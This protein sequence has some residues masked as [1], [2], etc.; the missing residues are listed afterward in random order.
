MVLLIIIPFLN[1]YFFGKI[2]PTFSDKPTW[3]MV[4]GH[5]T[6]ESLKWKVYINTPM[7][8][9][10]SPNGIMPS[11]TSN[12]KVGKATGVCVWSYL[13][14]KTYSRYCWLYYVILCYTHIFDN[15]IPFPVGKCCWPNPR[16]IPNLAGEMRQM[17]DTQIPW[18]LGGGILISFSISVFPNVWS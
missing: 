2:N 15:P 1:G 4:C 7:D 14:L 12:W 9:W 13:P 16:I 5:L 3:Y 10:S 6:M 18:C 17:I 8:W 11:S